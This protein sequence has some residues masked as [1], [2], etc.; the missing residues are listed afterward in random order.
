[1]KYGP[2]LNLETRQAK[3]QAQL[4][5]TPFKT[6]LC[7]R[8]GPG[9]AGIWEGKPCSPPPPPQPRLFVVWVLWGLAWGSCWGER[10]KPFCE[11]LIEE[12]S[13]KR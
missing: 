13:L 2:S 12:L 1:M 11:P 9:E 4:E 6:L 3:P 7:E 5:N 10:K 8:G